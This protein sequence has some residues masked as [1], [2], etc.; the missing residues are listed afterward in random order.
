MPYTLNGVGTHYYGRRNVSQTQGVCSACGRSATLTSYETRE[1]FCVLFVPLIPLR[2]WRI[3]D[4]CSSCRRHRRLPLADFQH[5]LEMRVAPLR[6]ALARAPRDPAAHARLVGELWSLH[7]TT[8]AAAAGEAALAAVPA[9]AD[10]LLMVGSLTAARGDSVRAQPLLDRAVELAPTS[11]PAHAARGRNLLRLGRNSEAATEL[12]TAVRLEPQDLQ[13]LR[14][15]AQALTAEQRWGEGLQAFER[16]IAARPE[17]GEERWIRAQMAQCKR[18]LGYPLSAEERRA[19]RKWWPFGGRTAAVPAP[20]AGRGKRVLVLLGGVSAVLVVVVLATAWWNRAHVDVYLDN[21]TGKTLTARVDDRTIPLPATD[22]PIKITLSPGDHA[23]AVRAAGGQELESFRATIPADDLF[24]ALDGKRFYVYNVDTR[25]VYEREQLGYAANAAEQ[26][27]RSTLVGLERFFE[28][29][30]VDFVFEPAPK[31]ISVDS[32]SKTTQ[33]TAFNRTNLT[34]NELA[35]ALF[36]DGHPDRAETALRRALRDDPCA[37]Q[38]RGNLISLLQ[39]RQAEALESEARA[40][41]TECPDDPIEPHRALQEAEIALGKRQRAIEEYGR[42][43]AERPSDATAHYLYGRL[44]EDPEL[45]LPHH[46]E[47]LRLDPKLVWAHVALA[48]DLLALERN[49]EAYVELEQAMQLPDHDNAIVH[50]LVAAAGIAGETERARAVLAAERKEKGAGAS[51]WRADFDLAVVAGEYDRA[52]ALLRNPAL[53]PGNDATLW[54]LRARLA[55]L[56]QR[57]RDLAALGLEARRDA[58]TAAAAA[59]LEIDRALARGD[60]AKAATCL[61]TER[62]NQNVTALDEL[63]TAAAAL[64]AG[65]RAALRDDLAAFDARL[66]DAGD[67]SDVATLRALKAVVADGLAPDAALRAA[68]RSEFTML[69][70]AYF[71]LGARAQADGHAAQARAWFARSRDRALDRGFPY[72]AAAALAGG[73]SSPAV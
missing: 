4:Q 35:V 31:E 7:M 67:G 21:G 40:W 2:R 13:S 15:M 42:R 58:G 18:G 32:G 24:D 16:L 34:L 48:Y 39:S 19:A 5:E 43:L 69:A 14:G 26:T 36:R 71:M 72:V 64:L 29:R 63:Y 23:L 44:L 57:D 20:A 41:V 17:A 6:D 51:L 49:R 45:S 65:D 9:D 54:E 1:C 22:G 25:R 66:A 12:G 30:D 10:L 28:Q 38:V 27:Y 37:R 60:Y 33:R 3:L 70:H 61:R 52:E 53:E 47:A 50:V 46:R 62:T 73:G 8:E 68:R 55:E 56:Q 59:R 11:G